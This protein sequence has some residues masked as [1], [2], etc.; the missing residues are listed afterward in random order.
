MPT[1]TIDDRKIDAKAGQTI[2]QAALENGMDVPHFCWHPSLSVAGN[3]RMCLVD[4]GMPKMNPDRTPALDD[5]GN[6]VIM[7]MPKLQIACATQV[8][9]GMV[10]RL[11]HPK[12][13]TAQNAVMEFLLVNHPLDCPICDEAGQ[14]KLQEY[15][16]KHSNGASRFDETKNHKDKRVSLGPNVLFDGERCISC[17]RCIRY[18]KEEAEQPVLSFVQRGDHVTIET[19]PGTQFD[20]PYS[21]NVIEICP[22]GALTSPDFRFKARV[23]DMSFNETICTGCSR[24]C[25]TQAGVRNNEIL[26]LEPNTNM[27]VNQYWMCDHGRLTQYD[28][29]NQNRVT[30]PLVRS[31]G[32]LAETDWNDAIQ[33][34][35]ELLKG[36]N[37]SEIAVLGSSRAT[38]EDN[39]A[40]ARLAKEVLKTPNVDFFRFENASFGDAKLRKSDMSPNS[41]GAD[42]VGVK[43]SAGGVS[44]KDLAAKISSGAIKALYV[45]DDDIAALSP[46]LA[47]ALDKLKVLIVHAHNHTATAKK[48]HVVFASATYAELEGTYTNFQNRVQHVEPFIVTTENERKMGMKMSR[49][50]KFGAHNDRWTQGERRNCR[51]SWRVITS[52]AKGLGANADAWRYRASEDVFEELAD[53]IS[54]FSGL[55]YAL[56]DERKGVVSGEAEKEFAPAFEYESHTLKPN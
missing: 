21:M 48:A 55:D 20:S 23:W 17:S 33:K 4:V 12:V 13:E 26:R 5:N 22:V 37:G 32:T 3:C 40:L 19:F 42:A 51:Q 50:D 45:L 46:E 54:F 43:P 8:S 34:A 2:I 7:F 30:K 56:L 38:N 41:I 24:G 27:D 9:E 31:N 52:L 1:I 44:A 18:A 25:N 47:S 6:P 29:V 53:K 39:Y 28:F 36:V 16:Y 11:G 35:T 10:V 14:C 15:G 49:L